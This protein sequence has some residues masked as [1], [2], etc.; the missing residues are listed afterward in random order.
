[1]TKEGTGGYP[2]SSTH[3]QPY[4]LYSTGDQQFLA[5]SRARRPNHHEHRTISFNN[6]QQRNMTGSLAQPNTIPKQA[7]KHTSL[8]ESCNTARKHFPPSASVQQPL[9][10]S[11]PADGIVSLEFCTQFVVP[12]PMTVVFHAQPDFILKA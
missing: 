7:P 10:H 6:I 1:V 4:R 5:L 11:L 2:E 3:D 12:S 9:A 8:S